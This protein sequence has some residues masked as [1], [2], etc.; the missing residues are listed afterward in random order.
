MNSQSRLTELFASLRE[1]NR[2]F[3]SQIDHNLEQLGVTAVQYMVLKVLHNNPRIG[4]SE[5][6]ELILTTN[7]TTSGVVDR[8]VKAG[9]VSRKRS[10]TDRRSV[11][12][13]LT[14]EG[15][16]LREKAYA[17]RLRQSEPLLEMPES[18][19]AELIRIHRNIVNIL[20]KAKEGYKHE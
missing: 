9:W 13:M 4:L 1:V 5:L 20:Q 12:L 15:E 16:A 17:I 10:D 7:S 19:H 6:S 14:Q 18:D 11:I 3:Y 8:M 2:A